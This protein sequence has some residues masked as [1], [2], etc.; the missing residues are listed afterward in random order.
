MHAFAESIIYIS[1]AITL[2]YGAF[3]VTV[4]T[5]HIVYAEYQNIFRVTTTL[6]LTAIGIGRIIAYIV[7]YSQAKASAMKVFSIL[8]RKSLL[9]FQSKGNI[10]LVSVAIWQQWIVITKL[11][12]WFCSSFYCI[13]FE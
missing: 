7:R 12:P 6:V 2:R 8:D 10:E 4:P 13:L 3:Q 9:E 5:D 11:L 1:F